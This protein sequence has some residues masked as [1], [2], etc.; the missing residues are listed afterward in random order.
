MVE[1]IVTK[2]GREENPDRSITLYVE[3]G[4]DH[5]AAYDLHGAEVVYALY[6]RAA[7]AELTKLV[8]GLMNRGWTD[9]RIVAHVADTW[10]PGAEPKKVVDKVKKAEKLLDGMSEAELEVLREKFGLK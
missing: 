10:K 4:D 1:L 8:K 3:M 2:T 9:E 6:K 5:N 7:E